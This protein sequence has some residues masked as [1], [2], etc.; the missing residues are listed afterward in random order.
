[1]QPGHALLPGQNVR[2]L[3]TRE[4]L[5]TRRSIISELWRRPSIQVVQDQGTVMP[6]PTIIIVALSGTAASDRIENSEELDLSRRTAC[7][8]STKTVHDCGRQVKSKVAD[9]ADAAT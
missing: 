3:Q 7:I 9:S 2:T 1:M 6:H 5:L 8:M 4:G